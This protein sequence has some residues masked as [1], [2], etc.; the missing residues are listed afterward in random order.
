MIFKTQYMHEINIGLDKSV[1]KLICQIV[2]HILRIIM[3]DQM[4]CKQRNCAE[5]E[6][7]SDRSYYINTLLIT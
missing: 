2:E 6:G 1:D 5:C 4:S 3:F 7:T